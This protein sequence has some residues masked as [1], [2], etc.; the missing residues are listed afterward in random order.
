M[1]DPFSLAASSFAIIGV[2]DVVLRACLKCHQF[3]SD[4]QDAPTAIDDLKTS[5]RNSTS[6][7][8]ALKSHVQQIEASASLQH[9]AELAPAFEQFAIGIKSL[10]RETDKLLIRCLKYSKM[11]KTRANVR[12]VLAEKDIRK[13]NEQVE[14][15]KSTLSVALSLVEGYV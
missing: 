1:A 10:R 12:H 3:L 7:L 4:V 2:A 5:L 9:R 8:Q 15:A 13:T 11:K 6:L 14:H